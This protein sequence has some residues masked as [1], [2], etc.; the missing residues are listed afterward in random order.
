MR[1]C[2]LSIAKWRSRTPMAFAARAGG[3]R[4]DRAVQSAARDATVR[5]RFALR[6]GDAH[7]HRLRA[8]AG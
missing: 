2:E 1:G 8:G 5:R 4:D 6:D 7:S 3:R